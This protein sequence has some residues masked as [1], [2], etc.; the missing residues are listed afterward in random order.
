MGGARGCGSDRPYRQ[1]GDGDV[2]NATAQV[3]VTQPSNDHDEYQISPKLRPSGGDRPI[4][5]H[6]GRG[7]T[8]SSKAMLPSPIQ[9]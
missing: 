1:G 9:V 8:S 7:P 3:V 2:S 4:N 5:G 6:L